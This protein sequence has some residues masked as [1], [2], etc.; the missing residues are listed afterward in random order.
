MRKSLV[1]GGKCTESLASYDHESQSWKTSQISLPWGCPKFSD[2]FPKS[3]MM[4]NGQLFRQE[5]PRD[6][7]LRTSEKEFSLL[8]TPSAQQG[9]M[10]E[11]DWER[12]D[13]D[14]G[15]NQLFYTKQGRVTQKSLETLARYNLLPT[16]TAT[17]PDKHSI[18]G[19][20]RRITYPDGQKRYSKGDYRNLPTPTANLAKQSGSPSDF[21]RK[22]PKL[23][24]RFIEPDLPIGQRPRLRP[25]FVV[26][27]MGFPI[28]WL[29]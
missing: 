26:W 8:P 7:E 10:G 12:L 22:T 28:D 17:D 9:G 6:S 23:I 24:T 21:S 14:K 27:M 1:F 20:T 15:L 4:R 16:P 25:Q 29:S 5:D 18:G 19:L 2:R 13:P 3:G 11:I